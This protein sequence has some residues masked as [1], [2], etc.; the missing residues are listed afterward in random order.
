MANKKN[1]TNL[2]PV[3]RNL[4]YFKGKKCPTKNTKPAQKSLKN[5]Q[6]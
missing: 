2:F 6:I 3:F 1:Y 5:T 4:L